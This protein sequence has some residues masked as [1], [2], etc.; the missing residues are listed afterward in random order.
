MTYKAHTAISQQYDYPSELEK[1]RLYL[2]RLR[3]SADSRRPLPTTNPDDDARVE[4]WRAVLRGGYWNSF[5]TILLSAS[6]YVTLIIIARNLRTEEYGRF[7]LIQNTLL[8]VTNI[9]TLGLGVTTTRLVSR[10]RLTHPLRT[11][12][13]LGLTSLAAIIAGLLGALV[14]ALSAGTLCQSRSLDAQ[15]IPLFRVGSLYVLFASI[16]AYQMGV[17]YG[18][19]AFRDLLAVSGALVF[20]NPIAALFM[21]RHYGLLGAVLFLVGSGLISCFVYAVFLARLYKKHSLKPRYAEV[22]AERR[23]LFSHSLPATLSGVIG[24]ASVWLC[25]TMLT[26]TPNGYSDFALFSAANTLRSVVLFIPNVIM[27]AASPVLVRLR[28]ED[29]SNSFGSTFKKTVLLVAGLSAVAAGLL[30]TSSRP[31]LALFGRGFVDRSWMTPLLLAA[32][33]LEVTASALYQTLVVHGR[34]W[35]QVVIM[36]VWA[37][38]LVVISRAYIRASGGKGLA[39]AYLIAW[40]VSLCLYLA[41]AHLLQPRRSKQSRMEQQSRMERAQV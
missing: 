17:M 37:T 27:R 23:A 32:S 4:G 41:A 31:L 1:M 6:A 9:S 36:A 16:N 14:M 7:A 25:N 15:L 21:T 29:Q 30:Y 26:T 3:D 22:F 20:V 39:L 18:L 19:E 35:W 11:N 8:T 34:L 2:P 33:V 13:I 5:S 38:V 24:S 10:F 40:G 12:G 28:Y